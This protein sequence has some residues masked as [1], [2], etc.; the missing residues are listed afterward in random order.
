M[1][2]EV[3]ARYFGLTDSIQVAILLQEDDYTSAA[4]K[5]KTGTVE[6]L[7]GGNVIYPAEQLAPDYRVYTYGGDVNYDSAEDQGYFYCFF[8]HPQQRTNLH[9][10][11]S[12]ELSDGRNTSQ[13]VAID[14]EP[15]LG[16][17]AWQNPALARRDPIEF[18]K[19]PDFPYRAQE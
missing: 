10:R 18:D 1:I 11:V 15:S 3:K 16:T 17:T 6:I 12:V 13:K 19:D 7:R 2:L 5:L 14:V 4:A 8:L 9:C